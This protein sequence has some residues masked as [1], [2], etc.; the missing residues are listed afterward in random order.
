[1]LIEHKVFLEMP[2]NVRENEQSCENGDQYVG[3]LICGIKCSPVLASSLKIGANCQM[4][5]I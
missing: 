5:L 3:F 2:L 4:F 1:M